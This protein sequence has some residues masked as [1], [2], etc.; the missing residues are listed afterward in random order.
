M[1]DDGEVICIQAACEADIPGID[2][3]LQRLQVCHVELPSRL[4][5]RVIGPLPLGIGGFSFTVGSDGEYRDPDNGGHERRQADRCRSGSETM[6]KGQTP[7]PVDEPG[8][9]R[10]D[11]LAAEIATQV[12]FELRGARVAS[13]PFLLQ[14]LG[15]DRGQI[16]AELGIHGGERSRFRLVHDAGRFIHR[17]LRDVVGRPPGE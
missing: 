16:A 3:C 2:R 7:Q 1:S 8:R 10:G 11:R 9:A 17:P 12:G 4:T 13:V 15:H 5:G 6:P 14:A